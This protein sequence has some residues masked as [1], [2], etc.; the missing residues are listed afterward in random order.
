MKG[1][2][3]KII[4]RL[5]CFLFHDHRDR[6]KLFDEEKS[7]DAYEQTLK[8]YPEDRHPLF[9]I[10]LLSGFSLVAVAYL[11]F[12]ND[13]FLPA[14]LWLSVLGMSIYILGQMAD[15]YSTIKFMELKPI[16]DRNKRNYP[17]E[18]ANRL[19]PISPTGKQLIFH[20]NNLAV[21]GLLPLIYY[22][23]SIG[24]GLFAGKIMI[25]NMNLRARKRVERTME[26]LRIS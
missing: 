24:I 11:Q 17:I 23:P 14:P 25:V 5:V 7:F 21:I 3:K 2:F 15:V 16:F 18:E 13:V 19:L 20:W 4:E 10:R 8:E 6:G 26:I 12:K 22:F 1:R 9:V